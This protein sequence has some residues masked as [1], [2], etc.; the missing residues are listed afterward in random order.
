VALLARI[1]NPPRIFCIRLA[2]RDHAV[3]TH[4]AIPKVPAIFLKLAS[5]LN[6][7]HSTVILPKV[8]QQPDDEAEFAFVVG[9][10]GKTFRRTAGRN[11]SSVTRS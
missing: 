2:Y 7:P 1:L 5:G 6:G 4:R 3:E 11:T 10:G 9:K 8:T